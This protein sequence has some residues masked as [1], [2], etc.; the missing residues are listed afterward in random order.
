MSKVRI[1]DIRCDPE[2]NF[3]AFLIEESMEI[4]AQLWLREQCPL[5]MLAPT[6]SEEITSSMNEKHYITARKSG[7]NQYMKL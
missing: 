1:D 5:K 6:S 7:E 3:K 4:I 2:V